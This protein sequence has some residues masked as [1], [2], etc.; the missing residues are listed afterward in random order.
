M[1]YYMVCVIGYVLYSMYNVAHK[2]EHTSC[3]DNRRPILYAAHMHMRT[4]THTSNIQCMRRKESR[5]PNYNYYGY[6]YVYICI[7][8]YIHSIC[9]HLRI[10]V[11]VYV[12]IHIHSAG[13]QR[14]SGSTCTSAGDVRPV[15][16][17]YRGLSVHT[18]I[19]NGSS[20]H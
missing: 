16:R 10:Y 2:V 6:T 5:K 12:Y 14:W 8:I 13:G 7:Y 4:H 1:S 3:K 15:G 9:T 17:K 11:D 18:G 20:Q 19:T